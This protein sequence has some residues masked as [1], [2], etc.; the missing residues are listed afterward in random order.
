MAA[1]ARVVW[2]CACVRY[3]PYRGVV[4][5]DPLHL[6]RGST[7]YEDLNPYFVACNDGKCLQWIRCDLGYTDVQFAYCCC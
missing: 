6:N 1:T 5:C 4:S 2:L 7:I 3:W